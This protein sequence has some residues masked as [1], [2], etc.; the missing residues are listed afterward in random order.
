MLHW[1]STLEVLGSGLNVIVDFLLAQI[2]HVA[3]EERF[4]M[5]LE[6]RLISIKKTIQPW[7]ELLGAVIGV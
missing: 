6:I 5:S 3:G 4:A 1:G 2:D 7:E